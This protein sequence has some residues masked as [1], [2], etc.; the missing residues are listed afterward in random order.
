MVVMKWINWWI[1]KYTKAKIEQCLEIGGLKS[2][3]D[4]AGVHSIIN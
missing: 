1:K 4:E 2:N 3:P